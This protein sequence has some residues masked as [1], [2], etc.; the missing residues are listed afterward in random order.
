VKG[1]SVE[2]MENMQREALIALWKETFAD[3]VPR[4][5][6]ISFLRHVLAFETQSRHIGGLPLG[7]IE[8]LAKQAEGAKPK[9]SKSEPKPGGRL[10][11]EWHGTTHVVDI[12]ENHYIWQGQHY[13]SLSAI[14]RAITG[15]HWSGPRFFGLNEAKSQ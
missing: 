4:R 13:R 11:R 5:V 1:V 10:L 14:A 9:R 3:P 8:R 15:A 6:S 7:F 2:Q 12:A